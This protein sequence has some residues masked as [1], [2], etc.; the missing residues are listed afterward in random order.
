MPYLF[1]WLYLIKYVAHARLYADQTQKLCNPILATCLAGQASRIPQSRAYIEGFR[2]SL[3]SQSPSH[4][5][6]LDLFLFIYIF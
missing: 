6:D 1:V 4:E 5:K 3:A 2:D